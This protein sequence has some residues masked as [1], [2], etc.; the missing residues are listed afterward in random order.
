MSREQTTWI[1]FA[2]HDADSWQPSQSREA[3][4]LRDK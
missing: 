4:W 3:R 1:E 2:R